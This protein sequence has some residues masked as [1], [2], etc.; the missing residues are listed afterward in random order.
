MNETIGIICT[1]LA[2]AG[3]VLNNRKMRPCFIMWLFS[4]G[5]SLWIHLQAGIWS[6]AFRDLIFFILA[7]EGWYRWKK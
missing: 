1:I 5:I 3:V 6:L 2:V 4:N 7:I